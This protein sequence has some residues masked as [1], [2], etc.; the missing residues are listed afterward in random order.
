[1]TCLGWEA[2][3]FDLSPSDGLRRTRLACC[4]PCGEKKGKMREFFR[5]YCDG[6]EGLTQGL[7]DWPGVVVPTIV[8]AGGRVRLKRNAKTPPMPA[9]TATAMNKAVSSPT[10]LEG[11]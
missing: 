6:P 2:A 5:D 9:A 10:L 11:S 8:V 1:M 3:G 4:L 7:G